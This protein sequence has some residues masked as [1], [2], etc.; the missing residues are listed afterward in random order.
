MAARIA[1]L[2]RESC[3][4]ASAGL[5]ACLFRHAGCGR[6]FGMNVLDPTGKDNA[7]SSNAPAGFAHDCIG[8]KAA[9]RRSSAFRLGALAR[10]RFDGVVLMESF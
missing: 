2:L 5:W 6:S 8:L 7:R 10:S 4:G 9:D 3:G 1:Q